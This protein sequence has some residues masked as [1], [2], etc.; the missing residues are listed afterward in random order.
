MSMN[1]VLF[2]T[3]HVGYEVV[4]FFSETKEPLACL[5][6]DINDSSGFNSRIVQA[7]SVE[8][9]KIF[10]SHTLYEEKTLTTFRAMNLDLIILAWWPYIV[11]ESL[12]EL[13]RLGCLNF[14]PSYLPYNR[15]KHYNFWT[16][17][18]ESPFGVTLHFVD[19]NIDTGD[20][21]YQSVIEKSWEDTGET[22]YYKAQKEIVQLFIEKFPEIKRGQIPRHPQDLSQGSFHK[23]NEL[24]AA[25][26]IYLESSYKA[27]DLLNLIRA[28]TFKP[29]P[30]AW[31]VEDG[32]KYEVR[33][34][35]TKIDSADEEQL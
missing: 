8:P 7:S 2:A 22:L 35:V 21:A 19:K 34:E 6:L 10:Y 20:I 23:G 24:E 1:I 16:I 27:R 26:Q 25:S 18:E 29:H 15:G 13:P 9:D 12:I 31:F 30:G 14:H 33:I 28:R 5:V 3:R 32:I 17:V 4:R 11:K